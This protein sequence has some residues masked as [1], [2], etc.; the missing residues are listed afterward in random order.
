MMAQ[1]AKQLKSEQRKYNKLY[2]KAV[3]KRRQAATKRRKGKGCEDRRKRDEASQ[4]AGEHW[5]KRN[6]AKKDLQ[7][8]KNK[9]YQINKKIKGLKFSKSKVAFD[10]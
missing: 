8:A 10:N 9:L 7:S 4:E 2:S 5:I 6:K 1:I 3:M